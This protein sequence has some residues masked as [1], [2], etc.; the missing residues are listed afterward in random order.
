MGIS[1]SQPEPMIEHL[2]KGHGPG[3]TGESNSPVQL[4]GVEP[5]PPPPLFKG[6]L[7]QGKDL[8]LGSQLFSLSRIMF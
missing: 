5:G 4:E 2:V 8:C 7:L 3:S 1:K 6:Q